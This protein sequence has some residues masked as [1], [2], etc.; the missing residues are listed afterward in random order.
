M[1]KLTYYRRQLHRIP[2]LGDELPKTKEFLLSR[3]RTLNGEITE[4]MNSG[5]AIFFA[6]NSSETVAFRSDMD[7]LPI[8]ETNTTDYASTHI[9]KMHACGHDAHMTMCL[10]L[11]EYINDE[12]DLKTNVL[13]IFQ[14][15]EETFGGAEAICKTGILSK[16]NV[17]RIFGIHMWPDENVGRIFVKSGIM[18]PS[19]SQIDFKI[20]GVSSHA[21][22]PDKAKD[23][24]YAATR[25]L[26]MMKKRHLEYLASS[27]Y[28][29]DLGS[30]FAINPPNPEDRTMLQICRFSSGTAR[31]I[32]AGTAF[33]SGTIRA[34]EKD[35]FDDLIAL[36]NVCTRKISKRYDVDIDFSFSKPYPPVVN[37]ENLFNRIYPI[38]CESDDIDV[39][40]MR[41]PAV[42]SEDFSYY[43]LHVPSVFFFLGTG[44]KEMLHSD[45]FDID[46]EALSCGLELY[47]LLLKAN[48]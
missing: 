45:N 7:A 39:E 19:S 22:T 38:L 28:H 9:G 17:T 27:G 46:E 44:R 21:T 42:I 6:G 10:S 37:D 1:N 20:E 12:T 8:E 23:A 43:G 30:G 15:A 11:A 18:Q 41:K 31:N 48:L 47:K 40:I 32:I 4:L 14:P 26:E 33:M 2:E 29:D 24:L 5:L 35:K 25:L 36:I 16:Y 34:Y 13:I 3:L